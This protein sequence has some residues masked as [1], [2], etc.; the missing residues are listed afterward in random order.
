MIPA[1]RESRRPLPDDHLPVRPQELQ[2]LM[3]LSRGPLHAYGIARA[4]A[5]G[6]GGVRLEIGSLYRMLNRMLTSGLITEA[7]DQDPLAGPAGIR[8]A[9]RIS[10]LGERVL[11]AEAR[12][13][14]ALV[15]AARR[16]RILPGEGTR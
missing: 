13:L 5:H 2:V 9:Y 14:E 8:R 16:D 11:E 12:R 4:S 3:T 10:R 1:M 7:I 15:A 6:D